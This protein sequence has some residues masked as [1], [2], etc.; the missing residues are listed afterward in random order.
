MASEEANLGG[1]ASLRLPDGANSY[2]MIANRVYQKKDD[3]D[4]AGQKGFLKSKGPGR[5]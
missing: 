1:A 3:S 5:W 2:I 4:E